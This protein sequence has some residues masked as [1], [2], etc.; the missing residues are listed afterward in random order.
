MNGKLFDQLNWKGNERKKKKQEEDK[1]D[2]VRMRLR[3]RKRRMW[4]RM[5]MWEKLRIRKATKVHMGGEKQSSTLT[6]VFDGSIG[7]DE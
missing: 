7:R 3:M 5:W 4:M 2:E 6:R 1:E